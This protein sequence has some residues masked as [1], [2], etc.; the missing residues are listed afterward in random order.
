[1]SL[2]C[3]FLNF[4][5]LPSWPFWPFISGP[6]QENGGRLEIEGILLWVWVERLLGLSLLPPHLC[7]TQ[8]GPAFMPALEEDL[9]PVSL[10]PTPPCT[11]PF[12]CSPAS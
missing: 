4:S 12:T 9:N 1:M 11:Q 6:V 2:T 7:S 8:K 10:L 3:H 5:A